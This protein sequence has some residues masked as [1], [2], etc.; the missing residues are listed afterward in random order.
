MDP[1]M[2]SAQP[3]HQ[4]SLEPPTQIESPASDDPSLAGVSLGPSLPVE[5]LAAICDHLKA[6]GAI[7]IKTLG[8]L[9]RVGCLADL[10]APRLY[11]TLHITRQNFEPILYGLPRASTSTRNAL[12]PKRRYPSYLYGTVLPGNDHYPHC[13][14]KVPCPSEDESDP[15]DPH[16]EPALPTISLRRQGQLDM[17]RKIIF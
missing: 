16:D 9:M 4:A 6:D 3:R 8:T 17:V 2:A 12:S 1:S 15:D 10:A 7:K 11:E 5:I 14:P 13:W